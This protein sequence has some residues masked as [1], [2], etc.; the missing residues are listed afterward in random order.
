MVDQQFRYCDVTIDTKRQ[1]TFCPT[2]YDARTA[3][4]CQRNPLDCRQ[5][6]EAD[7]P[8]TRLFGRQ[9]LKPFE[10]GTVD[11]TLHSVK[12]NDV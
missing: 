12:P 9:L 10:N 2:V 11:W 4:R 5:R 7:G 1:I 3:E 6:T 8:R